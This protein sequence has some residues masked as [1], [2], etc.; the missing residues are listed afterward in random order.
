QAMVVSAGEAELVIPPSAFLDLNAV[1]DSGAN[2][3]LRINVQAVDLAKT[4]PAPIRSAI[5]TARTQGLRP[6]GK[7]L[8]FTAE[9]QGAG[10]TQIKTFHTRVTVRIPFTAA[11]NPSLLGVY[12]LNRE[13]GAWEY[14]GGK[15][16]A[17]QRQI[18]VQLDGFSE[19]TV[20]EFEREFADATGH[21]AA[22]EIRE[23]AARHVV[24][25]KSDTSFAPETNVTRA[26]FA[27]MMVRALGLPAAASGATFADVSA[28]D[29]Y[30][31]PI[32]AAAKAGLIQGSEGR[33]RPGDA[34]TR[35]EMAVILSRALGLRGQAVAPTAAEVATQL[36]GYRDTAQIAAWSRD[37]AA[38][39]AKIRLMTGRTV[40]TYNPESNATRAEAVVVFKRLLAHLGDI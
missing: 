23:M 24:N 10:T 7:V 17:A 37:A 27:A 1:K 35:Q 31:A 5:D 29:W 33:F 40:F 14:R 16:N 13:T 32:A 38:Q 9:V 21:W 4:V 20:L 2:A 34:I 6:A 12:R 15:V 36:S 11:T 8:M 25:G 3:A 30:A 19:Y 28:G 26:E 22:A 18:E 39:V